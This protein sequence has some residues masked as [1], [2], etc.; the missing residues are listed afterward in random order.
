[1]DFLMVSG[2]KKERDFNHLYSN[3]FCFGMPYEETGFIVYLTSYTH[4][5]SKTMKSCLDTWF[6]ST[7]TSLDFGEEWTEP[8]CFK[9]WI[10]C[11]RLSHSSA[12]NI[13]IF[14]QM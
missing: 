3:F 13:C 12:S 4:V 2:K 7:I 10:S 11:Y 8:D 1:M 14:K 5:T 9:F 6:C